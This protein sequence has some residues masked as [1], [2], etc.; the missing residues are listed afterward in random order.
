MY[1]TSLFILCSVLQA[2][3]AHPGR[4]PVYPA[5]TP[6]ATVQDVPAVQSQQTST[7]NANQVHDPNGFVDLPRYNHATLPAPERAIL[8]SLRTEQRDAQG[9]IMRVQDGKHIIIPVREGLHVFEGQTL[10]NFDDQELNSILKINQAQLEVAK[11][12]RDKEIEKKYA[13]SSVQVAWAELESMLEANRRHAGVF[14]AVEVERARLALEQARANLEL[15]IYTLDEVKTRE[16]VVKESELDRTQVQIDLRKLV[17]PID[18]MV[19]KIEAAEG[20]WKREGDPILTIM[21][22]D[23]VRVRV[24]V[25]ANRF[26]HSDVLGKQATIQARLPNG[27]VETFQG[28]V[29][30]CDPTILAGAD[31]HAYI[32]VQNRRIGNFWLLLPGRDGLDV[33]IPL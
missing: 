17:A 5:P 13:A 16:V 6:P 30:F 25:N 31:F 27:S 19:V 12:E 3:A 18:G 26:T 22:L 2:G 32:E 20:E 9:N 24:K 11:A 15:Q 4:L 14:P 1:F 29:V 28:P 8:R 10:A 7:V 33:V 21:K 23:T